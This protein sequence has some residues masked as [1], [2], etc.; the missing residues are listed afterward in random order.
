[1]PACKAHHQQDLPNIVY[2]LADDL[3]YGDLSCLN[4][5]SRIKTPFMDQIA[6]EGMIFKNAHSPSAVCSPTRYG[7]LTGEYC[8]RTSLKSGVLMG[9][10]PRLI[11]SRKNTVAEIMKSAGYQ[12][13]CIGK[14]HLGLDWMRKDTALPLITGDPWIPETSN[15]D[16]TGPVHGG[17]SDN[18]F[19]YSF[20]I[21]ASLDITP[22]LYIRN[23]K[24]IAPVKNTV[25]GSDNPR[26]VFWRPGDIQDG[27]RHQTVL[28]TITKEAVQYIE[29]QSAVKTPFFLYF[30]LSAPHEP[31]LPSAE[32]NGQSGAGT[33][34]EFVLQ[35]DHCIGEI[36]KV[37]KARHLDKNTIFIVTSDNG[38]NW[39]PED[40][41]KWN[42][43][44]NWIFR[45]Q[46]SDAWEGGHHIPFL[47]RWPEKINPGSQSDQLICLTD[48]FA[49]CAELT[50]YQK[51]PDDG[52]DSYSF[53]P[54]ML[55]KNPDNP[56]RTSVVHHSISGMF[57]ITS[58]PWK[59]IDGKGSGGW[60]PGGKNDPA[61]GQLYDLKNDPGETVNLFEKNPV[62]VNDLMNQLNTIRK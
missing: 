15:V 46:K 52:R 36:M 14:W 60:S 53:F 38:S 4:P 27:F 13:A 17:P 8:F 31:W 5:D 43:K 33:Y 62:I 20:I 7:I 24:S 30:P 37:L 55:K 59:L 48:L 57:A 12:T 49:T 50:G 3:G 41:A 6:R 2:I 9:Y 44:G 26:G 34:G 1:M 22:Y 56:L 28:E 45:G 11:E 16:Y 39:T 42:H 61:A 23:G 40:I 54:V 47:V 58:G 21:P 35:V 29:N 25:T 18:G 51:K 32:F 10:S 19:D